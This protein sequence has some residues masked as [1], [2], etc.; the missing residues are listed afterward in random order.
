MARLAQ[1]RRYPTAARARREEGV[2]RVRFTVS[3]EGRV[4]GVTLA[5]S[6]GSSALDREA[7]DTVRRAQP[8]PPVP[9]GMP[10]PMQMTLGVAFQLR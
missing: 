4:S 8:L 9:A 10:A 1:A 5:G 6:S 7:M 2:A 3:R